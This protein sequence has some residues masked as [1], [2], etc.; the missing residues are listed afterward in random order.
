VTPNYQIAALLLTLYVIT[1]IA[2]KVAT[3]PPVWRTDPEAVTEQAVRQVEQ[4]QT[5][6]TQIGSLQDQRSVT[7]VRVLWRLDRLTR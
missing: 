3:V 4:R 6:V 7:R 2:E 5:I 1:W